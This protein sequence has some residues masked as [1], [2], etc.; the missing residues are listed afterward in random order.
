LFLRL[1]SISVATGEAKGAAAPQ[2]ALDSILSPNSAK[3]VTVAESAE[4]GDSRRIRRL[5]QCGQGFRE[6][7]ASVLLL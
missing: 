1:L 6:Q 7:R 2:P 3:S 4:F 5:S